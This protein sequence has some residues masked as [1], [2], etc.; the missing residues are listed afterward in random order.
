M[1]SQ[2]FHTGEPA[3]VSGVYEYVRHIEESDC[4]PTPGEREVPLRQAERFPPDRHCNA[5]AV[6]RLARPA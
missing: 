4:E 5:A 1:T 6:W 2:E 3:P